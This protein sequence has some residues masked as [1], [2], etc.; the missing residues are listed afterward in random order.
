MKPGAPLHLDTPL[1][2]SLPISKRAGTRVWLKMDALQP[3]GSF[4]IRGMGHACQAYRRR[5]ASPA[6]LNL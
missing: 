1:L 2:E 3:S 5:G 6:L 4:K